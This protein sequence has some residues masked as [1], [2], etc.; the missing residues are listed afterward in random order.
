MSKRQIIECAVA[1]MISEKVI[2]VGECI[3]S[4]R[5]MAQLYNVSATPVIDAYRNLECCGL[6]ESRHKSCFIVVSDDVSLLPGY[7]NREKGEVLEAEPIEQ[8][9]ASVSSCE[10]SKDEIEYDFG[11]T[12]FECPLQDREVLAQYIAKTLKT[13]PSILDAD[14]QGCDEESLVDA[15]S[16]YMLRYRFIAS[17]KEICIVNNDI[18]TAFI[19]YFQRI[20]IFLLA[21]HHIEC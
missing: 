16:A 10:G 5:K 19:L 3:P 1:D 8:E 7:V 12:A 18:S 2:A 21:L 9:E 17:K 14:P 4:I 20:L 11:K 13:T 15:L 6:I